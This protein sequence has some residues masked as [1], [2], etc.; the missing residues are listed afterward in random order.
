MNHHFENEVIDCIRQYNSNVKIADTELVGKA[1]YVPDKHLMFHLL[2]IPFSGLQDISPIYF[3]EKTFEYTARGIQ[4]IHLWQDYWVTRQEIVRSRIATLSGSNIR[5]HARRTSVQRINRDVM[6]SFCEV[7][8]LQGYVNARYNYGL[9]VDGQLMAAASFSAGRT[10][11]RHG[12]A[13]RSFELM[14]YSSLLH[15]RVIGG[16]GK[17]VSLFTKELNPDD[18]MTYADLDWASGKGY[19]ALHFIQTAFSPPQTFWIH[20][21]E[22]IRY[23][24]HRLPPQLTDEF[25][26]QNKY[27]N[28]DDF[29]KD[30][31]YIR[32]YNAGNLKYLLVRNPYVFLMSG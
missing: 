20:P 2:P 28:K 11:M 7:N 25:C 16:L 10:V 24:P 30:K 26:R 13:G 32:I 12:V 3:Q 22:M 9:L 23:Y 6:R 31:G 29:L 5:I 8:H 4:L 15:H 21:A 17:L 14:R 19:Q 1:V 18:I 27:A